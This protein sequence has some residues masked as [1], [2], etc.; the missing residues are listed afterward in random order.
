METKKEEMTMLL[1]ELQDLQMWLFNSLHEI[2]L[3]INF[4]VFENNIA[5]YGHV[6]F[7]SDFSMN[8]NVFLYSRSSYEENRTQLKYFIEYVKKLSKYGNN[9]RGN[10]TTNA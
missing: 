7:F 4:N 10:G 3:D 2:S 8:E 9:K 5:I 1:R 6:G